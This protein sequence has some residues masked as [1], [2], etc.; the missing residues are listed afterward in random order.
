MSGGSPAPVRV[1]A[2]LRVS[3]P[4]ARGE[5]RWADAA[6]RVG[7]GAHV[8]GGVGGRQTFPFSEENKIGR[9]VGGPLEGD[10]G[11]TH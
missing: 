7:E 9:R 11:Q 6:A 4:V 5:G 2:R 1:K 10:G 3:A 8:Q